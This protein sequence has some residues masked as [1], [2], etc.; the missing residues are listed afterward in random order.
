MS[1]MGPTQASF[2]KGGAYR[3]VTVGLCFLVKVER[4]KT[5]YLLGKCSDKLGN[6]Q[7]LHFTGVQL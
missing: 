4:K 2:S 1:K 3:T 5:L 6:L 7:I